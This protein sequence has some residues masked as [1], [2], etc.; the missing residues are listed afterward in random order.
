MA[1][2]KGFTDYIFRNTFADHFE[3]FDLAIAPFIAS[4]RDAVI[5]PKYVKDLLPE[6]NAGLPVVPQILSKSAEDFIRLSNCFSDMGYAAVNW[7]LGCPYPT[8]TRKKRGSGLL[9]HPDRIHRFLDFV[10]PRVRGTFS[11][12]IRLGWEKAEEIFKL[13]PILNQYPISEVM[14]HP[15]T[16]VQRYDGVVD[17]GAF[18]R[19]VDL[20][21]HPVVYNG[22][23]KAKSDFLRLSRQF[24]WVNRWMLG[25]GCMANPFLPSIIKSGADE[26]ED[27]I[28]KMMQFHESLFRAYQTVLDGPSHLLNRMKGF[29]QFIS[30]PFRN[31]K[32][33]MKKIYKSTHPDQY[34]DRVNRFFEAYAISEE[35]VQSE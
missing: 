17:L 22:D 33:P 30:L 3:G 5:R 28:P 1:P 24:D 19:C 34:L 14:I 25:R 18:E 21:D 31:C 23:I 8:V 10:M 26:V 13:I 7:N 20:I 11:I 4:K 16:G 6:N 2:M 27:R 32:K 35:K 15:R 9:P 12:K 29:W